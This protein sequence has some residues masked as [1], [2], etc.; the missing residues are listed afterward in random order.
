MGDSLGKLNQ[1]GLNI[2]ELDA[3]DSKMTLQFS[4]R[5]IGNILMLKKEVLNP[6]VVII[7]S[8]GWKATL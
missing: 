7:I 1:D 4:I 2:Y 8:S 3:T 6:E 5:R